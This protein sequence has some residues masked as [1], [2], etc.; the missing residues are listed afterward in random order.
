[1]DY[2]L[3]VLITPVRMTNGR[4]L[5]LSAG[6]KIKAPSS[7]ITSPKGTFISAAVA[8]TQARPQPASPVPAMVVTA[9]QRTCGR[10]SE[11]MT[12]RSRNSRAHGE[13]ARSPPPSR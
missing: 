1:M 8:S 4:T 6:E 7:A 5:R 3:T 12:N 10:A 2:G 11:R 9:A 13:L